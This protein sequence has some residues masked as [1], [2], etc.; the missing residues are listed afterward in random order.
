[1]RLCRKQNV[2][3]KLLLPK[4]SSHASCKGE[5]KTCYIVAFAATVS[6]S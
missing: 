5:G 1:M 2:V 3:R 6:E 4:T